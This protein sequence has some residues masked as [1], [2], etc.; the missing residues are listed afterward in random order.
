[1]TGW[2]TSGTVAIDVRRERFLAHLDDVTD[3]VEPRILQAESADPSLPGVKA[4]IYTDLPEAGMQTT[5]TYGLSCVGHEDWSSGRPELCLSV[6]S[7]DPAWGLAAATVGERLRGRCPFTY[8]DVI[9]FGERI[10]EES[11]MTGFLV[12]APAV[13]DAQDATGIDLGD[14]FPVTIQGLYPIY[15]SELDFID[16]RGLETFW[17]SFDF[18]FYDVRRPAVV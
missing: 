8:G 5:F 6:E 4:I 17:K 11:A 13:L 15:E 1:M 3:G 16:E 9:T 2:E 18:D 7:D 14:A 12:F 10:S